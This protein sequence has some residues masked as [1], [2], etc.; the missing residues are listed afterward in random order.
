MADERLNQQARTIIDSN[1]YM[2]L[3]TAD[4]NGH[5]WVTPV[6]FCS[7]DYRQFLWVSSPEARHSRNIAVRPEVAIAIFD[8]TVHPGQTQAVYLSGRGEELAGPE[9]ER[10]IEL[11]NHRSEADVDRS[12]RLQ[13]VQPPSLFRLYRAIASEHYVLIRGRDPE[14]GTGVDRREPVAPV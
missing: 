6:W 8:S 13:D 14:L 2:V 12:W 7:A 9:L 3:G 4:T 11:F 10:G 5:P 1:R